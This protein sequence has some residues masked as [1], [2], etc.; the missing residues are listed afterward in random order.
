VAITF[1]LNGHAQ[2]VEVQPQTTLLLVV[3]DTLGLT[4][5]K[6]DY[7]LVVCGSCTVQLNGNAVRSC[8]TQ[9]TP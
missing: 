7:G 3:R 1:T 2:T 9:W 4:G 8:V 5:T 6:F